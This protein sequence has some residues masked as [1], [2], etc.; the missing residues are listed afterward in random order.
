MSMAMAVSAAPSLA[1]MVASQ[2]E[3]TGMTQRAVALQI[4]VS[5]Q[6]IA[7]ILKG[8][9]PDFSTLQK[10]S[11]FLGEPVGL[12]AKIAGLAPSIDLETERLV[13]SLG[14]DWATLKMLNIMR[15][16]PGDKRKRLLQAVELIL[17]DGNG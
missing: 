4:G 3:K 12:L 7:N 2:L 16:L 17:E 1:E 15:R 8:A 9:R 5:P 13:S 6:T 11:Q 14:D 10:L